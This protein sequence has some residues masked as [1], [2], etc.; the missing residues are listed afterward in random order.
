MFISTTLSCILLLGGTNTKPKVE[1]KNNRLYLN[2]AVVCQVS[3]DNLI[4]YEYIGNWQVKL[5]YSNGSK[6]IIDVLS[7]SKR[8]IK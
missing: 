3:T 6:Y 4:K 5:Q 2:D 8:R 1:V 7:C